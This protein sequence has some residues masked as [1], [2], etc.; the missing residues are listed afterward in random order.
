MLCPH[1][2]RH[3]VSSPRGRSARGPTFWNVTGFAKNDHNTWR[4]VACAGWTS[5]DVHAFLCSRWRMLV[6]SFG[7][8][9]EIGDSSERRRRSWMRWSEH[10][11]DG[12][13]RRRRQT[14]G[15]VVRF[16]KIG[17]VLS[18][19]RFASYLVAGRRHPTLFKPSLYFHPRPSPPLLLPHAP[20]P[21]PLPHPR[22]SLTYLP[23][24]PSSNTTAISSG[25][26]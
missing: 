21:F 12:S 3:S 20:P 2:L 15:R 11:A 23:Y 8:E 18:Q 16:T 9:S 13:E 1:A 17:L 24:T 7:K 5:S 10:A 26:H 19:A 6:G 22:L 14:G 4:W 25:L